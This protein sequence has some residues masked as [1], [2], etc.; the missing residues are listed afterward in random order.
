MARGNI[1]FR[2]KPDGHRFPLNI[3]HGEDGAMVIDFDHGEGELYV[4][5][6]CGLTT[7]TDPGVHGVLRMEGMEAE[8]A[9][10]RTG[11]VTGR[12]KSNELEP[13]A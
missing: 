5:F 6:Y 3:S 11:Y 8:A 7:P 4:D 9:I 13:E 12:V 2:G 1:I 10:E